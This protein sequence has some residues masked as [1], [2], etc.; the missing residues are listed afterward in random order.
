MKKIKERVILCFRSQI[1]IFIEL[2][3]NEKEKE[4]EKWVK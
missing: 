2:I 4:N 3:G 1:L